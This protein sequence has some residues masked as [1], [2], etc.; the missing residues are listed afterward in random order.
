LL[1]SGVINVA[2]V[3]FIGYLIC[4]HIWLWKRGKSTYQHIVEQRLARAEKQ[5][6]KYRKAF[7]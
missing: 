2:I 7:E 1:V 3:A 6:D 4:Y 5:K